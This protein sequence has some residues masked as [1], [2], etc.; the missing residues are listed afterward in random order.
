MSDRPDARASG[1]PRVRI[2]AD[3]DRPD[4]ILAGLTARQIGLLAGPAVVLWAAYAATRRLVP[5]PVFGALAAPVVVAALVVAFGRR[6][7]LGLDRLLAAALRHASEPHHLVPAP[8]G[9]APAPAWAGQSPAPR[10]APL[11]LPVDR[12]TDGGVI[13]LGTQGSALICQASAVSFALRTPAEQQAITQTFARWLNS[14]AAPV[15][16]LVRSRPAD[17]GGQVSVLSHAAGGLP[18]PALERAA[19]SHA[20]FLGQLVE[21]RDLLARH[22]LIVLRDP[23]GGADAGGRLRRRAEDATTALAAAGII[24]TVLDATAADSCMRGALDPWAPH[25]ACSDS[26]ASVVTGRVE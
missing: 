23:A 1:P 26:S 10:P 2:P 22:V 8:E 11:Q 15:Q 12:V 9:V 20:D 25:P 13:D 3:V 17:L 7:G 6:D 4:R 24:L 16:V 14:L 5:L 19:L 21:T 18:H